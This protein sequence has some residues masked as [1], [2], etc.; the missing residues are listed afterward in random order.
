M[1][2]VCKCCFDVHFPLMILLEVTFLWDC[3]SLRLQKQGMATACCE[4]AY[5]GL[6]QCRCWPLRI[7]VVQ[8]WKNNYL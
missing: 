2:N 1:G 6:G 5:E 3:Y 4:L 7:S 8:T